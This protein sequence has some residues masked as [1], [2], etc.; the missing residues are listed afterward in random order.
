MRDSTRSAGE[1]R[2]AILLGIPHS[3]GERRIM[4]KVAIVVG[5]TRPGRKA[6]AVAR[7]VHGIA[8]K[9]S[10]A[11]FEVVDIKGFDLP[12]LDEAM[13]PAMGQYDHCLLYTSPSP[14]D[15]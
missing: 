1:I 15:L 9:R 7:W 8:T 11:E 14:R 10:D 2:G 4:I 3:P 5:S 12:L 13:P 6:E